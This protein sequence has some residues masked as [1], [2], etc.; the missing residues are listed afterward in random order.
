MELGKALTWDELANEYDKTHKGR[1]AR[2]MPMQSIFAWGVEQTNKFIMSEEGT[3][4]RR[5]TTKNSNNEE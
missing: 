4:H 5:P 3:L 1:P 2:T